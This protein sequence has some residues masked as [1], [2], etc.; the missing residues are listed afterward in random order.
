M[1]RGRVLA[2]LIGLLSGSLG[3]IESGWSPEQ[4][5]VD[6]WGV[7]E[8]LPVEGVYDVARTPD[9]LLW[10]ATT[11]G[12]VR[13]DGHEFRT[14]D[15]GSIPQLQ[16]S[17]FRALLV[18]SRGELWAAGLGGLVRRSGEGFV[19]ASGE[20]E[21]AAAIAEH[22]TLGLLV[23]AV[24]G[25][26]RWQEG[27][28]RP[29]SEFEGF[30][31]LDYLVVDGEGGLWATSGGQR[32]VHLSPGSS[33]AEAIPV[34]PGSEGALTLAAGRSG[35]VW[36][37][38]TSG[39]VRIAGGEPLQ[40][41]APA[42]RSASRGFNPVYEDEAGTLWLGG[43][44]AASPLYRWRPGEGLRAL[45]PP[46]GTERERFDIFRVLPTEDGALWLA[47]WGEGLL[48]YSA[49]PFRVDALPQG[50]SSPKVRTLLQASDGTLWAGL[51]DGLARRVGDRWETV[52]RE[53]PSPQA[54]ASGVFAL[55]E[56]DG[57]DLWIGTGSGIRRWRA[58]RDQV[59]QVQLPGP[60]TPPGWIFSLHVDRSGELWIGDGAGALRLA[61]GRLE[62]VLGGERS[63][64]VFTIL[65][66]PTGTIWVGTRFGLFEVTPH[67]AEHR[68]VSSVPREV[69]V[70]SSLVDSRGDLWFGMLDGGISRLRGGRVEHFSKGDGLFDETAHALLEDDAGH[71]W[72]SCSKGIFAIAL[73]DFD[74]FAAGQRPRL[75]SRVFGLEEGLPTRATRGGNAHTAWKD[76]AGVLWFA[77]SE[78]LASI[79]PTTLDWAPAPPRLVV[80]R[81]LVD[82]R[83][84]S[85]AT[86]I[87][88][89]AGRHRLEIAYMGIDLAAPSRVRYR[90]RLSR[91]GRV[92][93]WSDGGDRRGADFPELSHGEYRFEVS[94]SS[95]GDTWS[96]PASLNV[97]IAPHLWQRWWFPLLAGATLAG[98]GGAALSYRLRLQLR[99]QRETGR[100]LASLVDFGRAVAG[101]LEPT[102]VLR[103]LDRAIVSRFGNVR[104]WLVARR[105]GRAPILLADGTTPAPGELA[106]LEPL[107]DQ[108]VL[109][110][111][112]VGREE[113]PTGRPS[114]PCPFDPRLDRLGAVAAAALSS[115]KTPFGWLAIGSTSKASLR[116]PD[117][118]HLEGLAAQ[119]AV[120]L[121]GAWQ[122]Q[123]ALRW[124]HVSEARTEWAEL[125][126]PSRLIFAAAAREG[127]EEAAD[128][129]RIVAAACDALGTGSTADSVRLLRIIDRLVERR[130][131]AREQGR[132]RIDRPRWLLLP[133]IRQPLAEIARQGAVRVG[134]FRLAERL[135]AGGMGE[136]F[137]GIN[138]HDGTEAAVKL[139][140]ADQ[141]HNPEARQRF[142]RE[143]K[144]VGHLAHPHIVRLLERGEYEGRLYLAMELLRGESLS[145]RLERGP[146]PELEALRRATELAS[147]LAELH[148][149]GVVHRDIQPKNVFL[150]EEGR[151]VLL[152]FGLARGLEYST[153]TRPQTVLGTL[154]YMSPEQLRGEELDARSDLWS[155]GVVLYEMLTGE[156]PWQGVT[157]V[158]M[159]LEILR[160][161]PHRSLPFHASL[162]TPIQDLLM[163]LLHPDAH[164]RE[165]EAKR[166]VAAIRDLAKIS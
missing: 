96:A 87:E 51:E 147:A 15:R 8:G 98:L 153:L 158:K 64:T 133:E 76:R 84:R 166:V 46:A 26:F 130:V 122:A 4:Y 131:L 5:R 12:L 99:R 143:G 97:S 101:I 137:R 36:L 6:H 136:V 59:E 142:D 162:S 33:R 145:S 135:G 94:T 45:S 90:Y 16:Q 73:T 25:L 9:G 109:E 29:V 157:T 163:L 2:G 164:C 121:E 91:S 141:S 31:R 92:P 115:G 154:P 126:L 151:T 66:S 139:L 18:D 28:L 86:P 110:S 47:A 10:I 113:K 19:L 134:A 165:G 23:A 43:R 56:A 144:I 120:A 156:L 88:L 35:T 63:P 105:E 155:F 102:E 140:Y 54:D 67:G 61:D 100:E 127:F 129:Q 74:E 152:D 78:G 42:S 62:R 38:S 24:N 7:E 132:I 149:H 52:W 77:T 20:A 17:E 114:D 80:E 108:A 34:V 116:E 55:A 13:F 71:L 22:P 119:A 118:A 82:G 50:L 150:S 48:R 3:A 44:D 60:A 37:G 107:A 32:L 30:S 75:R 103:L 104:R 106:L 95:D 112:A 68:S 79:D 49:G 72:I 148:Q 123:E 11:E 146:L 159:A 57:G 70:F 58:D 117:L 1:N 39:I 40:I 160:A 81:V 14:F 69:L 83:P 21:R 124:R 65:E 161:T 53:T 85:T 138:V 125:D 27:E 111:L 128:P 89:P 93:A 41:E